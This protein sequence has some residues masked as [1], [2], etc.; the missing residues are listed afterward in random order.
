MIHT[1][2]L[3]HDDL[4]C[5]DNGR[6]RRGKE[7]NHIKFGESTA[8]LAGDALITQA[9]DIVGVGESV[10]CKNTL[11]CINILASTS[12]SKGMVL[13]Q[14]L[15][16][17]FHLWSVSEENILT[18]YKLKTAQLFIAAAK[19]GVTLADA[20]DKYVKLAEEYAKNFGICFQ[21]A[22]D[23]IDNDVDEKSY[24]NKSQL[25]DIFYSL[26]SKAVSILKNFSGDTSVLEALNDY[27][28]SYLN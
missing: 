22:D 5:M 18:L 10:D 28:K 12:G 20:E 11:K 6:L 8:L 26:N 7:C 25:T 27:I 16:L 24:L 4:P 9:F 15:D 13:G 17:N 3:I 23:L 21:I 1:Y 19:I 14:Y 2:S